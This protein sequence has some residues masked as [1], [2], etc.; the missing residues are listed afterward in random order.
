M[1]K[2]RSFNVDCLYKDGAIATSFDDLSMFRKLKELNADFSICNNF[3]FT[4][5]HLSALGNSTSIMRDLLEIRLCEMNAV[6]CKG[7]TAL[8]LAVQ[9]HHVEI[10]RMLINAGA[11]VSVK[12][13]EEKSAL[14]LAESFPTHIIYNIL[15]RSL[16]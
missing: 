16:Q 10:V 7:N 12:S 1:V 8:I 2:E 5:L 11:D 9:S 15:N 13:F 14:S 6:D 4:L 3:D